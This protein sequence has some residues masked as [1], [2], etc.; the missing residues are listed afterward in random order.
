MLAYVLGVPYLVYRVS[1]VRLAMEGMSTRLIAQS[2]LSAETR[3]PGADVYLGGELVGR[4]PIKA[5][6]LAVGTFDIEI[7]RPG[8]LPWEGSITLDAGEFAVLRNLPMVPKTESIKSYRELNPADLV[9]LNENG[10]VVVSEDATSITALDP[11]LETLVAHATFGDISELVS[12]AEG[13]GIGLYLSSTADGRTILAVDLT[14][15]SPSITPIGPLVADLGLPAEFL[16]IRVH[17]NAGTLLAFGKN[18]V[19]TLSASGIT[20]DLEWQNDLVAWGSIDDRWWALDSAGQV[21]REGIG[22]AV[23]VFSVVPPPDPAFQTI[24]GVQEGTVVL[25]DGARLMVLRENGEALPTS[26]ESS[27]EQHEGTLLFCDSHGIW[28][29]A[30]HA[31]RPRLVAP[32]VPVDEFLGVT[33]DGLLAFRQN[34]TVSV[35]PIALQLESEV[36]FAPLVVRQ[37]VP[38]DAVF[39]VSGDWLLVAESQG[40]SVVRLQPDGREVEDE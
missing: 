40:I 9:A 17:S 4:T 38:E 15:T 13:G 39:D 24:V 26:F 34:A 32:G 27:V 1:A 19:Y 35:L 6:E 29:L 31:M 3:P 28:A 16:P 23:E 21:L 2:G 12:P 8:S 18:G 5:A 7:R 36:T 22:R 25:T 14:G 20:T 10:A 37:I 33:K 11:T 30:L